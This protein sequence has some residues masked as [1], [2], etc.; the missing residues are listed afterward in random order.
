MLRPLALTLV[1][2]ALAS[3]T[4]A[5]DDPQARALFDAMQA[6]LAEAKTLR[7]DFRANVGQTP[8]AQLQLAGELILAEGGKLELSTIGKDPA[9]KELHSVLIC[10]GTELFQL[11]RVGGSPQAQARK[12]APPPHLATRFRASFVKLTA[13]GSLFAL[14]LPADEAP[15]PFVLENFVLGDEQ[16]LQ[17]RTV[18]VVQYD[19][20]IA[21]GPLARV[22]VVIDPDTHLPLQR[23]VQ[24]GQQGGTV[25]EVFNAIELDP[26]LPEHAF[27]IPEIQQAPPTTPAPAPLAPPDPEASARAQELLAAVEAKLVAAKTVRVR[28]R[29]TIGPPDKRSKLVTVLLLGPDDRVSLLMQGTAQTVPVTLQVVSDGE[30]RVTFQ[31]SGRSQRN[32]DPAAPSLGALARRALA[33]LSSTV[34]LRRDAL[35]DPTIPVGNVVL[36]P[37]V[38]EDGRTLQVVEYDSTAPDLRMHVRLWIDTATQLPARC[39]IGD[40]SHPEAQV[41]VYE[42]IELDVELPEGAF[43]F[44]EEK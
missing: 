43:A 36:G 35:A 41:E 34:L 22:Q 28:S 44:P 40:A 7:A 9:G 12:D 23:R 3:A 29:S 16:E 38:E 19:V 21:A 10:D 42:A 39:V 4:S 2:C 8:Q 31:A 14:N 26:E 18:R 20:R 30:K 1:A 13:L 37:R 25:V 5:D 6:K 11:A 32:V 33:K 24:G 15:D 17:G 27:R